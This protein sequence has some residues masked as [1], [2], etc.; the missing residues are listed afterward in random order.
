M[1]KIEALNKID[2]AGLEILNNE[3]FT[4]HA[5]GEVDGYLVRSAD[6]HEKEIP[7]GLLAIARAGAGTN[8]IPLDRCAS[9]GIVVFNTP[10]ANAN[11]VKE[12]V[13]CSLLLSSRDI[14]GGI[15][16]TKREAEISADLPKAVEGG[17]STFAGPELLGKTIGILGLG[18]IG[19]LVA[20]ACYRLGMEVLGYD[21]YLSVNAAL[22]LDRHIQVAKT[23]EEVYAQ[24]DYITLHIPYMDSTKDSID[25]E[26]LSKMKEGVKLINL[27]RGEL[28]QQEAI[29]KALATG[30]VSRYITDFPTKAL[31][32]AKNLI[33]LPH[34]G[35]STPDSERNCAIMAAQQMKNYLEYGN[36]VNSVNLPDV[37]MPPVGLPRIC[38]F[39]KNVPNMLGQITNVLAEF[40]INVENMM[41]KSR[42][43]FAY[44][45]LDVGSSIP[46]NAEEQL[47][48]IREIIKVRILNG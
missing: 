26:A 10:G 24:A 29:L 7:Y 17:K 11:A 31:M 42:G 8:N 47:R 21:P 35:A 34:L 3:D 6:L 32:G 4:T 28:V 14:V 38:V 1:Y 15:N 5:S 43:D 46:D 13:L 22:Q 16:W 39:H 36:I 48:G 44:T 12:L 18:A 41:N 40:K 19:V 2:P 30:K 45:M 25:E 33:A 23:P 20:N 37:S 9:E 27:A